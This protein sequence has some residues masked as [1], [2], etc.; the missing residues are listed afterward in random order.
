MLNCTLHREKKCAAR[1]LLA[2]LTSS[3][4]LTAGCG[5]GPAAGT[6]V[7]SYGNQA[8]ITGTVHGGQQPV[9]YATVKL[10]A[11]G[12]TGYG[13]AGTLLATT[14][15]ANG[16]GIFSFTKSATNGTSSG[17]TSSW[18]CPATT[19]DPQIYLVASGGNAIGNGL[20]DSADTNSN[21]GL[22]AAL[23]PC[24]T[25]SN[26]TFTIVDELSTVATVTALAQYIN[27]GTTAGTESIGTNGANLPT[28]TP[29]GA[30]GLNNAVATIP[31]LMAT[32][33]YTGT[34]STV[35]GVTVTATPNSAKLIT[36]ANILASCVNN[37]TTGSAN[38][39]QLFN[40]AV[41]PSPS[42]TSQPS[43]T[44]SKAVDT[45]QAAYYMATNPANLGTFTSCGSTYTTNLQCLFALSSAVGAAFSGGV[46]TTPNDWTLGI[47]YTATGSCSA[48]GGSFLVAPVHA[49]V[50]ATGNIWIMNY[51]VSK[52]PF[53]ELSPSGMPLGCYAGAVQTYG[54][55]I[56]ID[57]NGNVWGDYSHAT[58][59]G[60]IQ[61]LP[62]GSSSVVAWTPPATPT[63]IA[64]DGNGNVF[65]TTSASGGSLYEIM[66]P[67]ATT[68]AWS[69]TAMPQV[70][71][72][73]FGTGTNLVNYLAA[74]SAGRIWGVNSSNTNLLGEYPPSSVKTATITGYSVT[75]NV[76][77]FTATNTFTVGQVV[78]ITGLSTGTIFNNQSMVITAAT[79]SSFSASFTTGNVSQTSDSGTATGSASYTPTTTAE[80]TTSW[81]LAV[82]A[83]NYIY[84]GTPCCGSSAAKEAEKFTPAATAVSGTYSASAQ[85]L[86]GLIGSRAT[87]V[88]GAQN[89][90]YGNLYSATGS[91]TST[92][93]WGV[94][95]I[96]TSGS[97][98]SATFTALSPSGSLPTTCT[99]GT[100]CAAGGGFQDPNFLE[101]LDIEID[102]SGNVW[103]MNTGYTNSAVTQQYTGTSVTEL[104]GAAVPIVTPMSIA[105]KN[106]TIASKP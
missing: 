89:V 42:V 84:T 47:T 105:A 90:W 106:G 14:S 26:N 86:G 9:A 58:L 39:T 21:I 102:P 17:T 101:P 16:T 70:V 99:T 50:D 104:V 78:S 5:M 6:A 12:T 77:T 83:N 61:E 33:S 22:L 92:G 57:T 10:Y 38:C 30:V 32:N 44:F 98:T 75:S 24:S 63:A 68:T 52:S 37:Q 67:G 60:L 48:S 45:I 81:G 72:A 56:T 49:A 3:V 11:A 43:A 34:A 97:G 25:I 2:L 29:Q 15:T 76:V 23:G 35:S 36:M 96:A 74:D 51:S 64:A 87:A 41:P 82:G 79:S 73:M 100:S 31:N 94:A 103:V 69:A 54:A 18:A 62:Y 19:A 65:F 80:A 55:N 85:F 28:N 7:N 20:N 91:S 66:N 95:E 59:A 40:A 13:S 46:G 8:T 4:I 53:V 71:S 1:T 27:P 88:D 93:I